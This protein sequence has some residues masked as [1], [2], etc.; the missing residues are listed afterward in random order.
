MDSGDAFFIWSKCAL[1]VLCDSLVMSLHEVHILC[2][3][4]GFGHTAFVAC[5]AP[6]VF[7][8][9]RHVLDEARLAAVLHVVH[10]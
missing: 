4:S 2:Q 6:M 8:I 1:C 5:F 3:V 9:V 10:W 7:S